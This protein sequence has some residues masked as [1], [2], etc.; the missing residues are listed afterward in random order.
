VDDANLVHFRR[1]AIGRDDGVNVEIVQGLAAGE[2]IV[3]A[4][5]DAIQDEHPV[6]VIPPNAKS[7]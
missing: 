3:T 6:R 2:R 1:V 5:S 4:L 7:R